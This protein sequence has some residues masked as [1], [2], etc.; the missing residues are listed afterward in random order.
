MLIQG[1]Q[2]L[3]RPVAITRISYAYFPHFYG[4]VFLSTFVIILSL[5]SVTVFLHT[6]KI[7]RFYSAMTREL[8]LGQTKR[9]FMRD[10]NFAFSL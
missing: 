2:L 7:F 1:S 10:E 8:L 9:S 6:L 4:F 3:L 5:T